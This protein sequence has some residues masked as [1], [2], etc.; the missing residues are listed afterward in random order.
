M[1]RQNEVIFVVGCEE[2]STIL[3]GVLLSLCARTHALDQCAALCANMIA[4]KIAGSVFA[5]RST[6]IE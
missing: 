1:H 3:I 5:A 4:A 2:K 6:E